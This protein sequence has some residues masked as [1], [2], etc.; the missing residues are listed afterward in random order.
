M[1]TD[2]I[3]QPTPE[4]RLE[5]AGRSR[6]RASLRR[7]L[8]R[9][10]SGA[11]PGSEAGIT[12]IEVIVSALIVALV[13]ASVSQALIGGL[14]A[15]SDQKL[16][17]QA[18]QIAQEDQAR[19]A[20]MSSLQLN[21]LPSTARTVTLDGTNFSVTSSATFENASGNTS[22]STSG[23]G[24]SA[25]Y[26]VVSSVTWAGNR[27]APVELDSL[28]TPAAGGMLLTQVDNQQGTGLSGI[29]VTATDSSGDYASG[30]TGS[31][32]CTVFS[33]LDSGSFTMTASAT[34]YVDPNGNSSP[35]GLNS[36]VT[37]TGVSV[38]STNPI[39]MGQAGTINANFTTE[40]YINATTLGLS[41]GQSADVLSYYGSGNSL[42]MTATK[43]TGTAGTAV[44]TLPSSGTLSLFPFYNATTANYT[45][46][47]QI[48]AGECQQMEPPSSIMSS[49]M[50]AGSI[51]PGYSATLP[52][53]EPALAVI[54]KSSAGTRVNPT[55]VKLSYAST[56]GTSCT[57]SWYPAVGS[58]G[59]GTTT[60]SPDGVLAS[61]GQPF[62]STATSGSTESASG[63][64]GSYTVCADESNG[65]GK[66]YYGTATLVQNTSYT[67]VNTATVTLGSTAGSTTC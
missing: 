6:R 42:N 2:P 49:G 28:I 36:T 24:A 63:E 10:V 19:M 58:N 48:W 35:P 3:T 13:G 64:T 65:S 8:L 37:S 1:I 12:L 67:S 51:S 57:D 29:N 23:A 55:A 11:K 50:D 26:K 25:F 16:R 52:I 34:G 47:Y 56:S 60:A 62:A 38:P 66:Y 27:D 20:G 4:V 43:T 9:R 39:Y 21:S 45:N 59:G 33:D 30:T 5:P 61:P 41:T 18:A 7:R 40:D 54:V 32:G 14:D 31:G 46:N 53:Q 15:S 17:S 44:T 22:C